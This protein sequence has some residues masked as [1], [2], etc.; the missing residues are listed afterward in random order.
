MTKNKKRLSVEEQILEETTTETEEPTVE[1]V[2]KPSVE[3]QILGA[4]NEIKKVKVVDY[5]SI[6]KRYNV[7]IE[8]NG[9]EIEVNGREVGAFLGL[10]TNARTTLK[11]GGKKVVIKNE[12][13]EPL[14]TIEVI[15]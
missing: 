9:R 11:Q 15:K 13:D 10:D 8:A 1:E 7:I 5:T 12:K 3:E 14:Y 4:S 6:Q 2:I